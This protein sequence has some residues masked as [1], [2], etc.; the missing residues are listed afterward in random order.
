MGSPLRNHASPS[1]L[2]RCA[3]SMRSG[4]AIAR[5]RFCSSLMNAVFW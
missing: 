2:Y 5:S 4:Y 3:A 1:A